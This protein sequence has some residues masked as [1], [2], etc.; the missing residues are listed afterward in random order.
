MTPSQIHILVILVATV[1][2]FLWGRWRHD[3]VAAGSLLACVV[4]GLV[5]ANEAFAGFGHPAVVTVACVLVLSRG[6]Q[7]S[8]AVD[9]LTRVVLPAK[10]G[11]TLSIG[12]LVALAA[13][14]SGFMN[15][16]GALALL[17]PVAIQLAGRLRLPPATAAAATP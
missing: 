14:L 15:N 12:V 11:P 5:P 3:M 17:M 9:A 6:L 7:T 13:V 16:V 10:A 2:M 1:A 4:A 8:G